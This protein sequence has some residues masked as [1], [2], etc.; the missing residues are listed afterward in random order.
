M[1]L[2]WLLLFCPSDEAIADS[3]VGTTTSSED[4]NEDEEDAADGKCIHTWISSSFYA[5]V[6][7]AP[8]VIQGIGG[9]GGGRGGG[10]AQLPT[11]TSTTTVCSRTCRNELS[12]RGWAA[13][14]LVVA[15]S[16]DE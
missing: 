14:S 8:C 15:M 13:S 4:D 3:T 5:L 7:A 1:S 9:E 6:C 12:A 11:T 2:N 16:T 10:A